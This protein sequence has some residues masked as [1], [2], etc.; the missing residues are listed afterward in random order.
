DG[1]GAAVAAGTEIPVFELD[2]RWVTNQTYGAVWHVLPWVSLSGGYFESAQFAD[3]NGT[4]LDSRPVPPQTGEGHDYGLRFRLWQDRI[5][6]ALTRFSTVGENVASGVT[7]AV[8][9]ELNPLLRTPFFNLTD[10]RDRTSTGTEA[11]LFFN[12]GRNWTARLAY[13]ENSVIF[14]RF[15]PL[16]RERLGEARTTAAARGLNADA[17]TLVTSEYLQ[18]QEEN[19]LATDRRTA[20]ATLRYA[21]TQGALNGLSLGLAARYQF[22]PDRNAINIGGQTVIP[23]T[24][25]DPVYI[26]SPFVVYRHRFGRTTWTGQINVNNAFDQVVQ[27]S[28]SYRFTRYSDPRQ[29]IFTST[30]SF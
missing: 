17:A 11:E 25:A 14:T 29:I 9:D 15:F 22:L 27:M 26:F 1:A 19:A 4:L 18:Q 8:R 10:L 3:N 7:A 21:F 28:P 30:V 23:V 12:Y 5:T 6:L 13:S 2:R 20:N 16:V 24:K